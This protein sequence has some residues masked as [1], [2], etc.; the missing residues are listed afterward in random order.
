MAL[1]HTP[2]VVVESSRPERSSLRIPGAVSSAWIEADEEFSMFAL[3]TLTFLGFDPRRFSV[4]R[5]TID[6]AFSIS[7]AIHYDPSN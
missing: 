1:R 4:F 2:P 7:N 5:A 3:L 6:Y